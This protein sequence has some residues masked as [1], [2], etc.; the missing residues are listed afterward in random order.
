[1]SNESLDSERNQAD[2]VDPGEPIA[3]LAGFEHDV[4]VSFLGRIRRTIGRRTTAAQVTSFA[5]DMPFV[6]LKEFWLIVMELF[7][8][9]KTRKDAWR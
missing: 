8:S 3:E 5:F 1:M 7:N 9:K 6:V 2:Q 4:S